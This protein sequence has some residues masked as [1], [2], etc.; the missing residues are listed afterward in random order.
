MS[1]LRELDIPFVAEYPVEY[2]YTVDAAIIFPVD[3]T[4]FEVIQEP[5][6]SPQDSWSLSSRDGGGS[7]RQRLSNNS[8]P[9]TFWT[10]IHLA[11]NLGMH[12]MPR[13][14]LNRM[15]I[16]RR[17]FL[18]NQDA[19]NEQTLLNHQSYFLQTPIVPPNRSVYHHYMSN[20]QAAWHEQ[21][22]LFE[23]W[24]KQ[25]RNHEHD[26]SS[27]SWSDTDPYGEPSMVDSSSLNTLPSTATTENKSL[28]MKKPYYFRIAIEI[29]GPTH[30]LNLTQKVPSSN[31]LQRM[32]FLRAM[33]WYVL[34]IPY[35]LWTTLDSASKR[36]YLQSMLSPYVGDT[37][38][39]VQQSKVHSVSITRKQPR[40]AKTTK[41]SGRSSFFQD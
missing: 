27:R 40:A 2:G 36:A 4:V 33:G 1:V 32:Y 8:H 6:Y 13:L 12:M 23:F 21:Y 9:L 18:A 30:Y 34:T 14:V 19:V 11:N 22:P 20:L 38:P 15:S 39:K 5:L 41:F 3:P 16:F 37:T 7:L 28:S 29:D 31:T 17:Y 26:D 35:S 25:Q 10:A 24:L